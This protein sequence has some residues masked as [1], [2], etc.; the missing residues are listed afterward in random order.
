[1]TLLRVL[2]GDHDDLDVVTEHYRGAHAA[3]VTKSGFT[4]FRRVERE[5]WRL[6]L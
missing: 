5:R 6:A 1:V 2:A 4:S 3:S